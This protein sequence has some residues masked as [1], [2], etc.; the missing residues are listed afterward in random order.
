MALFEARDIT[1]GY[2]LPSDEEAGGAPLLRHV[3][4]ALEAGLIYDLTGPSGAGKSM[5]L[6]ACALMMERRTGELLLDGRPSSSF[7][8]QQW[9]SRVAL[10]PQRAS[11]IPGT[12]GENLRLPWKLRVHAGSPAP[13][14]AELSRLL[15][16]AALDVPLDRDAA[17][18]SGGQ[19]ARVA[20]LR[21]FATHPSVLLL[22]E[23]DAALDDESAQAVGA[24]TVTMAAEGAACLRIR[25]RASDGYAAGTF[26]LSDGSLAPLQPASGGA[27]S[28]P[29]PSVTGAA[30]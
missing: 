6:R 4:F 30:L 12:V 22:D 29:T 9:R 5:L 7:S 26:A 10:V 16:R 2:S 27:P 3:G 8:P 14:D 20:L 23:V 17:R 18:L 24:L 21:T 1:V 19:A 13:S 15:E 11:L 28:F 25:H